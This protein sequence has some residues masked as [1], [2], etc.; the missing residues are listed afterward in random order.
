MT[1]RPLTD[2]RLDFL[3][4][5]G[6]CTCSSEST[7]IKILHCWKSHVTA[8]FI[9]FSLM[10]TMMKQKFRRPG[11]MVGC[12]MT[13]VLPSAILPNIYINATLC[14]NYIYFQR[15]IQL[16]DT[17]CTQKV[18]VI[19][20]QCEE[21]MHL[22]LGPSYVILSISTKYKISNESEI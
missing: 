3:S 13:C 17:S 10:A 5:K 1:L 6:G 12:Q 2:H 7:L 21:Y 11:K 20:I 19:Q 16:H 18:L 22:T 8:Q 14:I 9:I 4:L 15:I